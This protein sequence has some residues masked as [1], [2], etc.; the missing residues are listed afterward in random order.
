MK[1]IIAI[2]ALGM[3]FL[4]GCS[5]KITSPHMSYAI[6]E[7][8]FSQHTKTGEACATLPVGLIKSDISVRKAAENGGVN[9]V[10][11]VED[12]TSPFKQCTVVYGN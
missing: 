2:A 7:A 4:T 6:Q 8:D 9:Q 5:H 11:Y 12:K 10:K 1:K 3:V